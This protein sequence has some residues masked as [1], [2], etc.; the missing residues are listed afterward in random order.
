MLLPIFL[1]LLVVWPLTVSSE[2]CEKIDWLQPFNNESSI[3]NSTGWFTDKSDKDCRQYFVCIKNGESYIVI[4]LKCPTGLHFDNT[5]NDCSTEYICPYQIISSTTNPST[6]QIKTTTASYI[7]DSS[8]QTPRTTIYQPDITTSDSESLTTKNKPT[9]SDSDISFRTEPELSTST[10]DSSTN[11]SDTKISTTSELTTTEKQETTPI[12]ECSYNENPDYFTCTVKGR[13]RNANDRTC[14]TYYLCNVLSSGRVIQTKYA[15]PTNSNFNPTKQLCDIDY[16]CPCPSTPETTIISTSPTVTANDNITTEVSTEKEIISSTTVTTDRNNNQDDNDSSTSNTET[17]ESV[18]NTSDNDISSST[19]PE[20]T[21]ST[22]DSST[23][24]S[25]TTISTTTQLTT[26]EKQETTPIDECSY[27]E[28]PDYFTCTVKGR[29]RNANDRTCTTYYLCNILSSGRVIQT[30]YACPTNSNFNPAKQLCDIDYK[31]PC[32]SAPETTITSTS[33]TVTA[34]DN[35]TTEVSTEKEIISSTTVTTDRN[36]N[37]DDNDS[38]TS[39]T[40]TTESVTNTSDNDISSSTVPELTSSTTDS[41]TSGSDTTISTTPELTT[42]E[43]QETTPIDECSYNENPDYFTCTVKGRFRNAKD[44]T[45]TTYF[46]CNVLSS[47]RVIQTKYACPTN[48]N[49]NPAKQLCDID[50]KC[51]C[52][53]APETTITSTSPTVTADDNITTEVSTEKEIISS[54]TVTTDRNNNQDDNDSSTS[55]TETTESETNTSDNNISSRTVPELTSSTTDSSTSGSDTTISTISELTTTEKQKTTPIDECSYNENPDY[56]TCTVKGRFRNANDRT[57]TTYYLCNILSSGRV[58][59]TKYACPTNSN[60]NPAK[61]LCDIDYKC[62]CPSAPETTITSTSPTVTADDNI[63]TEVSTEKEIISSTTVTTD[64]NNNQ[65]DNDSSTSN[66][67][68]TE[69]VTNTSDNDISSSTV[70][71][72]TSS[73][74]DSSTSGSD[75]TISTTPELTTTEKQE[76]TPIDE[77]SYNE[78][79]DYFTCT[80]K[81][82]F[83]NANDRTCTTYYLCNVLSSGRVI[84][85]KYACPTNSNFNPAKQ[86]CDIDYKCPCPSAPETTI[87]ST[88]STVTADDNI[89][90]EV[91][92]E[93]EIISSTTVTTD[94]NNNQD[95]NDSSTSNTETTESVTNTSDNDISSSTVPE[96]TSSTTDSS[97]SGSDT[98]IS[99]TPELTTTE[100]QETTPIDECSYNENP[101]YFTCTVKGRFRNANDRTCTTYFLCNVLSSGRV[102]QTKYACPTNSNFNPAKQ[103][104]DIDYKCPC[105]SAPETTITST[106]PTVTADDNITTEVSTEKE[107]ISSTTVTTDRNDNQDDNDSSTSN[108]ETTE[109]VTNTSDNDISSSTVPELTSSTTD[110]STSGSDTTISTTPELTTTEKQETTPIDECSYNEN[111]NYFTCTVKGRFRNANDRTCTTYFLCN[112]LSSGRVI[113]TKYACPTN[114]NF[115]P[116]K[117]LCDIDY[118]CPCPSAPETTITSTSPTVTADDNITTEVSTEKEII[119]STTVTTDRNN[120]QDDNDSSTSNTETTESVTNTSD[121]DI[122]SSTVPELTSST[123]DSSTSGSDTTISTTPELTTTEK[124]ETTPI[125]EC[126][127]NEN[128]DYFT[129]TVKGRFRNANDRTCTTYFLCNVL[130]S[131][132]VIQTKYAC[133][134]N[135]NFNP[136]KQLCDIDYKCPCPSAPETTITST[137]STVT[138]D[139]NITT[140]VSTEKEIISSTTV[141]TDRNDNQDDNDSSTS[142]TE[143]TESVTNTSDNDISSSTVPELTSSTTDS[144]TSGSDTT[145]STTPELTTTEKQETTPIDECSY[146]ENPNYFTC[147]VKG[148]FRNANDRTC[149]TYFLCNVLSSGRV[150]QTKYACPTNSNFNPAKQL[151]DI[152]YKCP[153]PSAPETTITSTSPTVTADDNITTEVSTEKEIISSTTV[154]TDRNNNQDDNDSSTSNTETTESVTN[155]SDNDI[156]SSTVPELTSSTTDSS[157]SGSDTTISTTPELTTTEKQETTPIDECSYNENPDYFTCTVKGRFRNA[158]DRT[159][160]TYFLCNVLSS[161]RVIQTKYAC[162]T[163]SNFNPAKQLCD[164]DYKCPCPSAPETTITSTSS[165]VTADDNI[166]TEVST[167][168]EIIS[169]TTVTTDRNNNQDDNDSSTSNTETTE[170]V[171]NTSDND[172]SSSTVPELTSSTTDSSTSGSDT[173]ISTTP[174]LTTTEKQETTPIDE[175]SYNENPDYFTCTVKG[176]FRNANDRTCTTYFLCNVLSSGR[177]IQTKYACP[178]NSNFNPAKQLCDIDYKCP[179]P[180]APETTITS[181]SPTVTADDNITTEVSTEKEIISSTTVTTDRNDNQDDNDSSTSNTETTE[182]VTNTSDNDISS[183][184]VPELTSS[185]TDSSTSGSD[186]TISTTPELTTTEKQE[187]TPIDEC[188]YNEN[189][190]YFTCTVKG[191]FRNANDRTCTTYYLCNVLSS[192]RVIQTKYACPTN[193]NFNPAKQLCDI[194]YKCPCPSAPETTITSTS[195]TVTADDNITTEVSTEKEI[196]SSTTVTTDRNNN[197]DDNDS[198]TSNTET[199]ESVTNTS[200]NDISSSTVPELTSST[201]DSSTS[202]SD[203]TISTTPELT[204]TE[205]QETTPIDECFYNENPDYFICTVKGRFR[206]ANDRTCTTYYLCNVL[207]SGRVIQTKYACPTNSNFNPSKQLCD[208]D[209]KCPCPSAPETTITST[210]PTVTADDNITTEVSTEK[211]IISSTTV[212]TDR[213]NNQD[214]NDS[215]TSNTETTESVTNTSDNDISSSTVPELTSSTTDSSTS[216]SDSTISTTPELTTTEK[217]ETTPIDECSYNEDLDYFTCTVKGRFR[218]ANDR[219]CTTYYLCNV[220]SSGRVIQT[221]YA[222]PTNSNFNPAKQ[223]CD[224]DYKCP[225]PSAPETTITS[226]SPT[227]TADDNITTEVSTEKEIISS[228]TVTTDRNNN[229]DDNDSS[230][231]NTETTESVTNTSDNDISSSTVPELTLSTTDSSTSG[232]DTTISTTPELTTTEKQETTTIDECS[233]NENPDYFTCT[234]KGRFRNANDR[235]CTTYFLCNVLSSGRVIQTKYACPTNSNFNPAKQLCDI[236]YKCPCPSAPETTI[237]STSPTVTADDNITTE[238][239]T[240]KEIISSTTVT[241][242]R[243][244]N[245]DDNDSSTSNTETTESVTNTSDNDI[246]SSTVPELTLSTTDSSTSGSDTTISTTPELTTTEKQET[247]TIDECSYNEN[248][249]YFTCTV[250]GRFRNA[251]DRTCTTYFLC[252]VLSSGRVIQT[253]YACPTNSN[254]NPAKQLCDIDYKCPC[255]SAPETTI[256]STSPTVTA[257]DNI[258]T[259]VSTEKEIISSTTVT[260]DRNNNQDDNDSSTS[261]TETT[262]SVTN[263]SDND[264]SSST[265]PELTSSTTDSSTSGS[266]TTISTTPELTTTEKQETTPIDECSYNENPNYFTCTVKGRFRNAND[267]TCTTYYLCNVLS[268]GRVIQ[269]KYA[270]PTNSNFNPAKQLCDIDY[271]CPCPSAP[272]TTITSTSPTVTA[273][274]NITTEVSTEKEI[275]SS[276]TVTTDRNNNQDDNDSST[277]N[278][279]TTESVTNTS[280]ND[281]SSS[282]VPELTSS[283]TDSS[284]SGSDTTIS[285]TPE[286]TTTEK[287]ETTPIDECSY[288]ENPDYFTC[289]VKGRFRNANDRTCTTYF[290]CNVLSSG[291]VIQTKYACPTNSNFNPAKQLCDIDYKCPCPSAPETTITSTSPTVTADDNITTEVSTEKEIISSTTVTTD[292]NNNQDDN[293]SST[294]NTETTE[295]VTNTSDND[296]SSSTVPELTSSTTDSSTS[297]SDTTISTTTQLTTTEKQETTPIDECSYNENPDYFT[298]T[299]KGRFRNANDRTCTTYYLCNVLSS[300]RVIQ[301]KYACPTNSN[302]NPAKQL[303]DIDYKC[304]CPS[305]PE[306]TI[307]STSPTVTADDNITTEVSTEKEIIS[308]TTVTTDRN[309]N[310]DDNDS[311]TSNTETTESVTNTSDNDISSSTVPELTSSTTDSST[312]G[313]DTTISTTPEL[314]TTEKQETTPIDECSYNENPDYFTCTVK[315]RFRNANDRTCTT[316]YLCNVLSSGR[317]I[318]TKYACPTNS[319]FNPA[320]QLCDIDYKC[321]CP[322]APET[323]ITSTSP[324]VTADDNITTEVSTEKEIISSTTVTPDRNNNSENSTAVSTIT[325]I[326]EDCHYEED[327]NYFTCTSSGS[328]PNNNDRSCGTYFYCIN[329]LDPILIIKSKY[330][331]DQNTYFNPETQTCEAE[332]LCPCNTSFPDNSSIR[333]GFSTT[334]LSTLFPTDKV[335]TEEIN[336]DSATTEAA[337]IDICNYEDDPDYFTCTT[338]GSFPNHNDRSCKTYF[339]CVNILDPI[340]IIKSQYTCDKDTYFNPLTKTCEAEYV[341]P[342]IGR[343]SSSTSDITQT[344]GLT[345]VTTTPVTISKEISTDET[346]GSVTFSTGVSEL[347]YSEF[348]STISHQPMTSTESISSTTPGE[349]CSYND[350]PNYFICNVKGRFRNENDRSCQT[351]YLCN[352]LSSGRIIQTKYSCPTN[353][354]FNEEKQLCDV[355]YKCPC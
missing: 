190:N 324:T 132:R 77:C 105:P 306:T 30:K 73:T 120:N 8:S 253:K 280:D 170:S 197:Q 281:I 7:E 308:S 172:I 70:P 59:Q 226:T 127:Y 268:S 328:F 307:T 69:S 193:S 124:Q 169:S 3:C 251:N 90:T 20:L 233:Y 347:T 63:T 12:D 13:F 95:D 188:S 273:D 225:C 180:S 72:L 41:S 158:N 311:S 152:D 238:V 137:S 100:K 257:D 274:D 160:T 349:K 55:N 202:G 24:G 37:Q 82:R 339:Y 318:Q 96:L 214:D 165:T 282:T 312:S 191:R 119:S 258:T 201:T 64:R 14:T 104:C 181:T 129:C 337:Q 58:I 270:C 289:T 49:F 194:D 290:L 227:V 162:P 333:P 87:T 239:S 338:S 166:T 296:I 198:S 78:N 118:K 353:S 344:T 19:V 237:T 117:Q 28:N 278:T 183:S 271:K 336:L 36:N 110:S 134:T 6:E 209:Y 266:D 103:L 189:P 348:N 112:V 126:S 254:F 265:V 80:V 83:R 102:I 243:N 140:E 16:K 65:D 355:A 305:A 292:R 18:T 47:G 326:S 52:P 135:S 340:L 182:S 259:E 88:S 159:C 329:V 133:P 331:C 224:I 300:G 342:C 240:E 184:T 208:I 229:Q 163:N 113:Q 48:S 99:T 173:T 330:S 261:N 220:L 60:F 263:T 310:Q 51:P 174:E 284:T 314:T 216:G 249:D 334:E 298:C 210:S 206:N 232:S 309:N 272:E 71:E 335:T 125:D 252:N 246:S 187:T 212:T 168:K 149:T 279:E 260:T 139:D 277:S 35:I 26:T 203:T 242:D 322:S 10:T 275:I 116:A 248:P 15:C 45:C 62:P 131:G 68:T 66:T 85:T 21:S 235:T 321:S 236:D 256:T 200:D 150:I 223:L 287:Q 114:S 22:T 207:S 199:T 76:T 1:L 217:Q 23:S 141:T 136:A 92:T 313:S 323:T 94:R 320:K 297:G 143:T 148:R 84:Q 255:P 213:N 106:S 350:D 171:T 276:T 156:S 146:N 196:I 315:G 109:S 250:K 74:T 29:F 327:P 155:T 346:T 128:P 50:Y 122:S 108:T 153:C 204:T 186:T 115:N 245:Q 75:T 291:R 283:T 262:E 219:T 34:D 61:Q 177:V 67:E 325:A 40:E 175:C 89:T 354:F 9:T 157:T 11:E 4:Y 86:L 299:V 54:T 154:T 42:T 39:N 352:V 316:Y 44:R 56:F 167:E 57:C 303:C 247:T 231:S 301:T 228:T 5:I 151:C 241:T 27:N 144:S 211:E 123:T 294:S 267:R 142:N 33:P 285:T 295:S 230:T 98:T 107:I 234:V 269:T 345:T 138:A 161:G 2:N 286:L 111:P 145:I 351:Y 17:T 43:K 343:T 97:T 332:Y 46:L 185:T 91:S 81:G 244:N 121:N 147:T 222:C 25:D 79:P 93:K 205:K 319:N 341:C 130:S 192:G 195:P 38:S 293:D 221:K 302:F 317:V 179:C 288:N 304:P 178:T 176:R 31:C 53:S 101:D 264:I 32:P 215:S 164:I 218:N